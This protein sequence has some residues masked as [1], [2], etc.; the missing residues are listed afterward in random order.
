MNI[1]WPSW[2]YVG[3]D[4]K[5]PTVNAYPPPAII[6]PIDSTLISQIEPGDAHLPT[7][8]AGW[9]G[10]SPVWIWNGIEDIVAT[11]PS[12][13]FP[14]RPNTKNITPAE[15]NNLK[16]AHIAG[17]QNE[18]RNYVD[19]F[20]SPQEREALAALLQKTTLMRMMGIPVSEAA[21]NA[22]MSALTFVENAMLL[23][24]TI[25]AEC[26]AATTI[27]ELYN[28]DVNPSAQLGTVPAVTAGQIANLLKGV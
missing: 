5:L 23:G 10:N 28:V 16:L 15:L 21:M 20:F 17:L 8:A 9:I 2:T 12:E 27:T 22:L 1:Y 14:P 11:D 19:S 4:D 26:M 25:S 6:M 13:H 18:V 7:G 3:D 24:S